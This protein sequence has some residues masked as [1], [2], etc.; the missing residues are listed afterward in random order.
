MLKKLPRRKTKIVCTL[1]PKS[2]SREMIRKLIDNGM[3]VARLNFS[4]GT[5]EDHTKVLKIVREEADAAGKV[6]CVFQDL[7]GPKVRIGE[8]E[9]GETI[10]EEGAL[11]TLFHANGEKGSSQRLF[12]EAFDPA[13]V[14]AI[15]DK[16][17]FGRASSD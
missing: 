14:V 16:I 5:H 8:I 15:G 12:V 17:P 1:G 10:L 9:N 2:N 7:C 11:I 3:D 4:H 13:A 6:V